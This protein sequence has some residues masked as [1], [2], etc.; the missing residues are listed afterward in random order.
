MRRT[1]YAAFAAL[2]TLAFTATPTLAD[3]DPTPTPPPDK[4]VTDVTTYSGGQVAAARTASRTLAAMK[5]SSPAGTT[6]S[7]L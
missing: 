7:R 1:R 5:C 6:R 3:T 4:T 2:L